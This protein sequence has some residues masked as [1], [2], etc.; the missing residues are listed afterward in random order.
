MTAGACSPEQGRRERPEPAPAQVGAG[1][2]HA[3]V[4][5]V[6]SRYVRKRVQ[7]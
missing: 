5:A 7:R 6:C 3:S 2:H 1:V 4:Y